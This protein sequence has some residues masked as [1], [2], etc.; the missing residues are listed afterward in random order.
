MEFI[1]PPTGP[2]C[3]A[4]SPHQYLECG[5]QAPEPGDILVLHQL[6]IPA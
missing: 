3:L 6:G 4:L 1:K 2:P 5:G